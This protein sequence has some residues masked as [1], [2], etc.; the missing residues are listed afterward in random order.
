MHFPT[1][2]AVLSTCFAPIGYHPSDFSL[3]PYENRLE[4]RMDK[5]C[6][7]KRQGLCR[8]LRPA[9]AIFYIVCGGYVLMASADS[10]RP[11]GDLVDLV[12]AVHRNKT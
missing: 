1:T 10:G 7:R 11:V 2:Y 3:S 6:A 9:E 8:K 5:C 12:D 4:S